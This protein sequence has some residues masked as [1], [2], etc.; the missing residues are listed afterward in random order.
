MSEAPSSTVEVRWRG[1]FKF[2]STDALGHTVVVEAPEQEGQETEG[3]LPGGLLL[4]ALAACSGIDVVNILRRQ[5]QDLT[6]LRVR[7]TGVQDPDPP[8]A[9]RE[10]RLEYELRGRGLKESAVR[11]AIH[12]SETKYCSVGA[13]LMGRARITSSYRIIEEAPS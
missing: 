12:L 8:W 6:A 3:M 2:V 11:R 7:V 4:T 9:Y 13:T 5:R 10:F 1:G